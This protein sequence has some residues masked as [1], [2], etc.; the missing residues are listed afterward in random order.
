M[1]TRGSDFFRVC[2]EVHPKMFAFIR[3]LGNYVEPGNL[4]LVRVFDINWNRWID[5]S[6]SLGNP[7]AGWSHLRPYWRKF[8]KDGVLMEGWCSFILKQE[9]QRKK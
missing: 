8:N 9:I 7:T 4:F 1:V 2:D 3:Y 5:F 6:I